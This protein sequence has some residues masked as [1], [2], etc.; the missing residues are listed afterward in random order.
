MNNKIILC[1]NYCMNSTKALQKRRKYWHTS[2]Y[3]LIPFS[4]AYTHDVSKGQV[5]IIGSCFAWCL[6]ASINKRHA[7]TARAL[8]KSLIETY[9][10]EEEFI[11]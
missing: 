2:F 10:E 5:Y 8:A 4:Y 1:R 6:V 7:S 9:V 3:S 11:E